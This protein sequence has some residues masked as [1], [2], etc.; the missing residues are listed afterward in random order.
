MFLVLFFHYQ[1]CWSCNPHKKAELDNTLSVY[2]HTY[3]HTDDIQIKTY[4]K[5]TEAHIHAQMYIY[6]H[7]HT[8]T[9]L[10]IYERPKDHIWGLG[11]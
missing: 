7:V 3:R 2:M 5:H 1:G 8:H 10:G 11:R 6:T 4:I 9:P